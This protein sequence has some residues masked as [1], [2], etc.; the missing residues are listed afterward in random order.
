MPSKLENTNILGSQGGGDYDDSA[1]ANLA[2]GNVKKSQIADAGNKS[3]LSEYQT[4]TT[5]QL[6]RPR[7][8][9]ARGSTNL[10]TDQSDAQT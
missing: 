10:M 6:R 5:R 4:E 8:G 1:L 7:I 3:A 2:K 9:P